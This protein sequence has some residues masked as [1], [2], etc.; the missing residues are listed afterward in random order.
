MTDTLCTSGSVQLKAGANVSSDL[1]G[2][3]YTT[4][5]NQA[6]AFLS[7]ISKRD[8]VDDYAGL[9]AETKLIL[10]DGASSY[11]AV[12][13]VAYDM[14]GFTSRAEAQTI[15]DVNWAKVQEVLRLLRDHDTTKFLDGEFEN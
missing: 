11:A 10:E 15:L 5:I 9:T 2:A 14:S 8:C 4:F 3:N 1:T 13:A 12:S 7:S 6:E